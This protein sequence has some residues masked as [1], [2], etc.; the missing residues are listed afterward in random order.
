MAAQL[1]KRAEQ[2]SAKRGI[3]REAALQELLEIVVKGRGGEVPARFASPPGSSDA[4]AGER[5][6]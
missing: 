2:I 4:G 5:H 6:G 3:S 1:L